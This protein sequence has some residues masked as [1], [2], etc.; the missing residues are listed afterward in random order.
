MPTGYTAGVEDGSITTL[1]QFA[2][3]CARAFGALID[4]RDE[5]TGAPIP[6]TIKPHTEYND[7]SLAEALNALDRV[8]HLSE[9][10][11]DAAAEAEFAKEIASFE[12]YQAEQAAQNARY[13]AMIAKVEAWQVPPSHEHMREF[14]LQQLRISLHDYTPATPT[15]MTGGQWRE[16]TE[17]KSRH[18]IAYHSKQIAEEIARAAE[19]T[20]WLQQLRVALAV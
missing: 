1:A 19:R 17:A 12:E 15:K 14:M 11:C 16:A 5:P 18:D 10:D 9:Y 4:M 13:L 2:M 7:M 6:L 8:V 3:T 20:E